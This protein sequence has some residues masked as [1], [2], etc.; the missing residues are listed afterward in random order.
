MQIV[1]SVQTGLWLGMLAV[2][3]SGMAHGQAMLYVHQA[4]SG[5]GDGSSWADAFA[6]LQDALRVAQPGDEVWVAAGTY[7]PDQGQDVNRG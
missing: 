7:R 2:L 5:V 4:A 3:V 1:R 6:S